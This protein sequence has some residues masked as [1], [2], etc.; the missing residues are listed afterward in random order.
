[1]MNQGFFIRSQ[2]T[3]ILAYL[4]DQDEVAYI[5]ASD[6]LLSDDNCRFHIKLLLTNLLSFEKEPSSAQ[7]RL[8]KK[9]ILTDEHLHFAFFEKVNSLDWWLFLKKEGTIDKLFQTYLDE[10]LSSTSTQFEKYTLLY[11]NYIARSINTCT[12]ETIDYIDKLPHFEKKEEF[13]FRMLNN[14]EHWKTHA[15]VKLYEKYKADANQQPFRRTLG[16]EKAIPY[17]LDW[18][19]KTTLEF[20]PRDIHL[21]VDNAAEQNKLWLNDLDFFYD[22]IGHKVFERIFK[23]DIE[24]GISFGID[25]LSILIDKTK[26]S[27][28]GSNIIRDRIFYQSDG[29]MDKKSI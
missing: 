29:D 6:K 12:Q 14:L 28:E 3:Q 26:W 10:D 13:V 4:K 9:H 17:H 20:F 8:A 27:V 2:I 22:K 5:K 23:I 18:V 19:I 21:V 25:V 15:P 11:F 1:M 24:K 7:K 16:L